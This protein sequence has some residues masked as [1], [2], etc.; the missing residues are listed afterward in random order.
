MQT[1]EKKVVMVDTDPQCNLT[2]MTLEVN[3][4]DLLPEDYRSYAEANI[5]ESLRPAIKSTGERIQA[6]TCKE[7]AGRSDLLLMAGSVRLSEVE[8]QLATAMNMGSMLPAMQNVPGSFAEMYKLIGKKYKCDYILLD[9]SPSLGSLNQVNFLNS[10][11]FVVPMVPDVFSVM[12]LRSLSEIIPDW[13]RWSNRVQQMNLFSDPDLV[14][15]F[16][17]TIPKFLGTVIQ[18][19]NLR[20]GMPSKSF[21]QY[22]EQLESVAK[23]EFVPALAKS[24]LL[25]EDHNY[26]T[27]NGMDRKYTIAQIPDF[28]SLIARPG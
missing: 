10:D 25:V 1:R 19:Y 6:P 15:K 16:T 24:G 26:S 5:Y 9:M 22:I 28:N 8:T 12:A 3:E 4:G 14:Y 21:Q 2:G 17:P 27:V 11:Y 20:K 7:V 13:I 18:R 23:E